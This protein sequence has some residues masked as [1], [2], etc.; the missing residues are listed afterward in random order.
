[1]DGLLA[2]KIDWGR[3]DANA[4]AQELSFDVLRMNSYDHSRIV[5]FSGIQNPVIDF[6]SA[7][8]ST[9]TFAVVEGGAFLSIDEMCLVSRRMDIKEAGATSDV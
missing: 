1:M 2:A 7:N 9:P 6:S 4:Q 8:T 5:A 3:N